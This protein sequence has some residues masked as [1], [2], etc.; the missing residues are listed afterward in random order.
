MPIKIVD[1]EIVL[2]RTFCAIQTLKS[3]GLLQGCLD[4]VLK[5]SDLVGPDCP[6]VTLG[7][8]IIVTLWA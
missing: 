4:F 1:L 5:I 6:P 7:F 2:F 8:W 3:H